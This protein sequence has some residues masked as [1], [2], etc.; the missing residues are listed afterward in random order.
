MKII[1]ENTNM[2]NITLTFE[3]EQ[4]PDP[5][6]PPT[7]THTQNTYS[8]EDEKRERT[9]AN[10]LTLPSLLQPSFLVSR[11][12]SEKEEE[13]QGWWGG[14]S[15]IKP[16]SR[17]NTRTTPPRTARHHA[18]RLTIPPDLCIPSPSLARSVSA[19]LRL[20]RYSVFLPLATRLGCS[21]SSS[22]LFILFVCL[23][24]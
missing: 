23:V 14:G 11:E 7:H 22:V 5:L 24:G 20:S 16:S 8:P 4:T 1:T 10:I 2:N 17:T 12:D 15:G 3:H 18:T 9:W 6:T 13:E 19:T 21:C